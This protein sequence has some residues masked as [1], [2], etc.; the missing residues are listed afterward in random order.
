[1]VMYISYHGF[2]PMVIGM[3]RT[4][5]QNEK[6]NR[7]ISSSKNVKSNNSLAAEPHL[8]SHAFKGLLL[9]SYI[10]FFSCF[11]FF[12]RINGIISASRGC[13]QAYKLPWIVL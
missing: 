4:G 5:K 3:D 6:K 11:S 2:K 10:Y 1:M 7:K 13:F 12:C 9:E 8:V